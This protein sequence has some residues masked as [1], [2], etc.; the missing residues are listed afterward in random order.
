MD[1]V[2]ACEELAD[3]LGHSERHTQ[4]ILTTAYA[5]GVARADH[6]VTFTTTD[7][8]NTVTSTSQGKQRELLRGKL[9]DVPFVQAYCNRVPDGE[10]KN[11]DVMQRV[12]ED[13]GLGWSE[14]TVE[15]RS[16]RLYQWLIFTE[17]TEERRRG[18]LEATEKMPR[19]NLPD[20]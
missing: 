6:G 15:T 14:G 1:E 8:G 10:F 3:Q 13:Y 9:L 4:K 16:K 7:I 5:L 18:V 17:L 2:D 19:G 11:K 20:L 12:S